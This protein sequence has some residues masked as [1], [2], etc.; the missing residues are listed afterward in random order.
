MAKREQSNEGK[1]SWLKKVLNFFQALILTIATVALAI[2][3]FLYLR[4]TKSM[5][6]ETKSMRE[7][8]EKTFRVDTS[9]KVF[10][11][12]I[13]PE[14]KFI[15]SRKSFEVSLIFKI[16]NTGETE[17]LEVVVDYELFS[18]VSDDRVSKKQ[19][20]EGRIGPVQYLF[21]DQIQYLFYNVS[22]QNQLLQHYY[23]M[24]QELL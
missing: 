17:A 13:S 14:M 16:V 22:S 11:K 15:D 23:R 9:P 7:L 1:A 18:E 4:E 12:E 8:A 5:R 6:C 24:Y 20:I 3:T 2:L 21:K 19:S 10:L